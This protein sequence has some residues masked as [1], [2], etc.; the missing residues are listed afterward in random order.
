MPTALRRKKMPFTYR[1][2]YVALTSGEFDTRI[3]DFYVY[4]T[5]VGVNILLMTVISFIVGLSISG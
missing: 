2:R 4:Q 3:T 5:G 1:T